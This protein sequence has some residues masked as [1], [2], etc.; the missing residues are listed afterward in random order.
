MLA[1]AG[2]LAAAALA[3]IVGQQ[4]DPR[5]QPRSGGPRTHFVAF[6]TVRD[7]LGHRGVLAS[8]YRL[9][10]D[11]PKGARPSCAP[12]QPPII[13]A[14]RQGTM[15]RIALR[16]PAHGWCAGRHTVTVFLERGPYCPPP[17]TGKPPTPCPL[18]ASQDLKV[19]AARFT[20]SRSGG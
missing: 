4:T 14:G 18:F 9:Q 12:P 2:A 15:A 17:G 16:A 13:A 5:V 7:A 8:D 6:F 1:L 19:G 3:G 10:V 20:V 11:A